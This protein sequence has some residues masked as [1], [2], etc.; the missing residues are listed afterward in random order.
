MKKC[1]INI[2][3]KDYELCLTRKTVMWL[4]SKGFSLE[5]VQEQP[6]TIYSLMF[7][8]G[9]KANYP[10]LDASELMEK[11]EEEGGDVS[12]VISFMINEYVTFINALT[13]TKSKTKKIEI[14]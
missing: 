4:E 6:I 9:F 5:K 13:D 8:A 3:E 10:D 12:E 7:E 1:K 11:Y 2:E 14:I